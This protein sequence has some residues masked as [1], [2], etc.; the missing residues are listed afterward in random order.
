MIDLHLHSERSHHGKGDLEDFVKSAIKK[1]IQIICFTEHAPFLFDWNHRLSEEQTKEYLSELVKLKQQ[2]GSRLNI[3]SGLE[4]DYSQDSKDFLVDMLQKFKCDFLLG[5]VH[6]IDTPQGK[7]SLWDY[8]QLQSEDAQ[9][10]YFEELQSAASCGL[11]NAIAHPDLIL[12]AGIPE[13]KIVMNLKEFVRVLKVNNVAYEINCS[14]LSKCSYDPNK[15]KMVQR[16]TYPSINTICFADELG[17]PLVIGSDAHSPDKVGK[18]ISMMI[19]VL[20][21]KNIRRLSYFQN[22]RLE[23]V[24]LK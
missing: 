18:N 7:I 19:D 5:S 6:F 21:R 9:K 11:F 17:V 3:L 16:S 1:N 15:K 14:G 13:E 12:R 24:Y 4:I 2:Y 8:E 10:R 20:K 22:K 23:A